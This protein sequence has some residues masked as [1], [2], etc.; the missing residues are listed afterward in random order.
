MGLDP[1]TQDHTPGQRQA[2]NRC[3]TQASH[4]KEFLYVKEDSWDPRAPAKITF[5]PQ[6]S[7]NIEAAKFL[8]EGHSAC[9]KDLSKGC[10]QQGNV[11]FFFCL[12]FPRQHQTK[13]NHRQKQNKT[14][15]TIS[16]YILISKIDDFVGCPTL[17]T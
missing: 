7:V 17:L 14:S 11:I 5:C 8:E 4:P 6:Q 15:Q 1:G 12:C 9:F 16:N 3:T 10:K 13:L 2:L